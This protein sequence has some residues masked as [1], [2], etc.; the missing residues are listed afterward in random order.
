MR[1]LETQYDKIDWDGLMAD[2]LE[3]FVCL[4]AAWKGT[5]KQNPPELH[6]KLVEDLYMPAIWH[7][8]A[9]CAVVHVDDAK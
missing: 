2:V 8:A 3:S 5:E 1:E 7:L 6:K 4:R 9:F